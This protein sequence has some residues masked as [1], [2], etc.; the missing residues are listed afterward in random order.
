MS[1]LFIV[2]GFKAVD[3]R[4]KCPNPNFLIK[5]LKE[6]ELRSVSQAG[7]IDI[8]ADPSSKRNEKD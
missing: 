4:I 7:D 8:W 1:D 2:I 3:L 5:V 6:W